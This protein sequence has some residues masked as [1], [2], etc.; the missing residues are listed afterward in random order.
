MISNRLFEIII[1]TKSYTT[2]LPIRSETCRKNIF[3]HAVTMLQQS[4][5]RRRKA[6]ATAITRIKPHVEGVN[7]TVRDR[8]NH[9][10]AKDHRT[11]VLL[12]NF[13]SSSKNIKYKFCPRDRNHI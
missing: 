1:Y 7:V 11:V 10:N 12:N 13:L 2:V 4:F 5:V 3:Q 8:T 9:P 6:G